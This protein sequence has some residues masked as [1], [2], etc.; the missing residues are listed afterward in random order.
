[1]NVKISFKVLKHYFFTHGRHHHE[2]LSVF[3][4]SNGKNDSE[5]YQAQCQ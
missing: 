3:F 5:T 4:K 2:V 1:M